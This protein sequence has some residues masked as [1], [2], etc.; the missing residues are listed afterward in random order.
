MDII[1]VENDFYK[2][3]LYPK[4]GGKIGSIYDKLK[5]SDII[6]SNPVY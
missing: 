3:E 2:V 5:K 4:F 6:F 1:L